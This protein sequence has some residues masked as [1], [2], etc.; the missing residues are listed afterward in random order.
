MK[1]NS[2]IWILLHSFQSGQLFVVLH[3]MFL[4]PTVIVND[5][6]NTVFA[7][8]VFL[9]VISDKRDFLDG[10]RRGGGLASIATPLLLQDPAPYQHVQS[11]RG[12]RGCGLRRG[13]CG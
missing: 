3:W 12:W 11:G 6:I 9:E 10:R 2:Y 13:H 5:V 8:V 1:L 7:I 4:V